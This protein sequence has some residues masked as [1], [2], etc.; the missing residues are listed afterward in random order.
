MRINDDDVCVVCE[1]VT[2]TNRQPGPRD[3]F[4]FRACLC[5]IHSWDTIENCFSVLLSFLLHLF[6]VY[7]S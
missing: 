6:V 4:G 1:D 2:V 3:C 5:V 7:F